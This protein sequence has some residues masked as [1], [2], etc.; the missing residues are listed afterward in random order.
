MPSNQ[1]SAHSRPNNRPKQRTHRPKSHSPSTTSRWHKLCNGATSNRRRCD[2][3]NAIQK[4]KTI[5]DSMLGARALAMLKTRKRTLQVL[6]MRGDCHIFKKV[7]YKYWTITHVRN[8]TKEAIATILHLR[9]AL[10]FNGFAGSWSAGSSQNTT[11]S[12]PT[13][14]SC[15]IFLL[16]VRGVSWFD[17]RT[18]DSG[19]ILDQPF[20]SDMV[21]T[22]VSAFRGSG[23]RTSRCQ[24]FG[25]REESLVGLYLRQQSTN[26]RLITSYFVFNVHFWINLDIVR[27]RVLA[28]LYQGFVD[29]PPFPHLD[30]WIVTSHQNHLYGAVIWSL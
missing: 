11:R 1:I 10:Q 16:S 2:T 23:I 12:A 19:W 28:G 5:N 8:V 22:V 14:A 29:E 3:S 17:V 9:R 13:R 30:P 24:T 15:S 27:I 25:S 18:W 21:P 26:N 7:D 4:P 20:S 6:R